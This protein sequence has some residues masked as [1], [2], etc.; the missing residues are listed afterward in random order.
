MTATL[1]AAG[2]SVRVTIPAQRETSEGYFAEVDEYAGPCIAALGSD[3]TAYI[4]GAN[5][6]RDLDSALA[7]VTQA[8]EVTARLSAAARIVSVFAASNRM[9]LA[10][11]W[12]RDVAADGGPSP[13]STLRL[14]GGNPVSVGKLVDSAWDWVN[15]PSR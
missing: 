1:R 14:S 4:V 8:Y 2:Y 5:T 10:S 6:A 7:D 13:A 11:A 9:S 3:L 15:H 12:L